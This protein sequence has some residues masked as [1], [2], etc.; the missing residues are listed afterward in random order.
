[1]RRLV[2]RPGAIGDCIV[3]LPAIEHLQPAEIWAPAQNLPLLR[4]IAPV[5]SIA[6]VGLD[7]LEIEGQPS[8]ARNLLAG[9]DEV[10]SWYGEGRME[11]RSAV[12]DL[13]FRFLSA[14]PDGESHATDFYLGQVGAPEGRKASPIGL[15]GFFRRGSEPRGTNRG[16]RASRLPPATFS[17][18]SGTERFGLAPMPT[19]STVGNSEDMRCGFSR[20]GLNCF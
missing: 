11:F 13:P 7:L 3:S 10:V 20:P 18:P 15:A 19:V 1:M 6:S 8:P 9:F 16:P 5:R 2:I 14:L 12:C 17:R 4:H